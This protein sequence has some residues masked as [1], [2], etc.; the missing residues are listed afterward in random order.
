MRHAERDFED[1]V[2]LVQTDKF[3]KFLILIFV[4][5]LPLSNPWVRGDGVGYYAYARAMLI[6]H[7]LDFR[8]DWLAA[9]TSFRM[10]RVDSDGQYIAG[11]I[12]VYWPFEQP[13]F[14]RARDPVVSVFLAAH[15][16][17]DLNNLWWPYCC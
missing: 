14:R 6:E 7:R 15:V 9:N 17:V 8:K 5:T 2:T 16:F 12:Y 13:L 3:E 10:G 4:L 1:L 11:S